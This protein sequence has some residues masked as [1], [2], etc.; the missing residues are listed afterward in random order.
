MN[1]ERWII[2]ALV[3]LAIFVLVWPGGMVTG[4]GWDWRLNKEEVIVIEEV[5]EVTSYCQVI[6]DSVV[7]PQMDH[8]STSGSFIHLEYW[9]DGQPEKET[10]LPAAKA[11]GG[12]FNYSQPLKGWVW[13]YEGCT[14]AEVLAQVESHIAR[15]LEG[16]ADNAGFVKWQSAG[17]F[18]PA[19]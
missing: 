12:R 1:T 13:E 18:Q 19:Q 11:A 3:I 6:H 5:E 8:V 2:V 15:R 7:T 14:Y 17:L 9:W 10:I 4:W 16:G